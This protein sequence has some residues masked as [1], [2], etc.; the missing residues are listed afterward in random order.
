MSPAQVLC[1]P[2]FASREYQGLAP[3][4]KDFVAENRRFSKRGGGGAAVTGVEPCRNARGLPSCAMVATPASEELQ[5][6][7]DGRVL[8]PTARRKLCH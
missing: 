1:S 8:H 3:R 4:R 2:G 7:V 5:V 6:A